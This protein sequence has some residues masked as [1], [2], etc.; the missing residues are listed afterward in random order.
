MTARILLDHLYRCARS[1]RRADSGNVALTFAIAMVPV[2]GLVGA[3]IDYSRAAATRTA[4]QSA[5]DTTALMLSKIASTEPDL[6]GKACEYFFALRA[7]E[8]RCPSDN[9]KTVYTTEG[10]SQIVVTAYDTVP[11]DF[12]GILGIDTI[13]VSAQSQVKWGNTRLRVA[14]V[15]DNTGSMSSAGKMTAL[16][17]ATKNLLDQLRAAT[18]KDGDIYISVIPFV[19]DVNVGS[20]NYNANWIYWGTATG[21]NPQDSTKSDNNSWDAQNGSCSISG[22]SP[23][24]TCESAGSCSISG[25]TSQSTC[26][27]AGT[28]SISGYS[29]Q[30]TCQAAGTCSKNPNQ[31]T[32]QSRCTSAGGTWSSGVWTTGKWTQGV[33]T[34]K[35]HS[36]WTGCVTDRGNPSGPNTTGNY[37]TNV[38]PPDASINAS[39]FAAEQYSSCPQAIMPLNYQW[40]DIKTMVDNMTANGN[41]NQAIGLAHGWMSLVGGGPYPDPPPMDSN[42][43]YQQV[44]ILMTDGLNTE[45]RWSKSASSIDARQK[46]TCDNISAANI[47]LYA[48]QVNT[49]GD[50]TSKLLQNCAGTA[51]LPNGTP[52]VYPDPNKFFLLTSADQ[53]ITTFQKIGTELSNLRIAQ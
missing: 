30:N 12:M 36:T 18:S 42:Y 25:K 1:F 2:I 52:R 32:T 47:T 23:R 15:L 51:Q 44:I 24:N 7:M 41:T 29:T 43:K 50:P 46:I 53:L 28:C 9:I 26:Q 16:K 20:S 14:L 49:D 5:A 10:G 37:D 19:K 40:N 34:P 13:N 21:T 17:T 4:M 33:W 39:L 3:A 11:T 31:N 6:E 45:N 8:P 48:I 35:N 38:S 22:K 27:S